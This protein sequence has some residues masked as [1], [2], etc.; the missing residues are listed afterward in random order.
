MATV[1]ESLKRA[2][3]LIR[4]LDSG[5]SP[6]GADFELA[7]PVVNKMMAR[8]EEDGVAVGWVAISNSGDTMP[9]P[10]SA[11]EAIEANWAVRM[12]PE[13]EVE[14]SAAVSKMA[15]DGYADIQRDSIKNSIEP[16][17]FS[18]LPSPGRSFNINTGD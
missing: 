9:A 4:V 8:W 7:I 5:A 12:A 11:L 13:Y 6:S 18:H 10:D 2:M 1:D 3:R 16:S 14:P 15:Q 17:D